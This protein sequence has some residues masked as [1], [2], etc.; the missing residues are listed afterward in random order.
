MEYFA[1]FCFNLFD[2]MI[3]TCVLSES[4]P[5]TLYIL[6]NWWGNFN[7]SHYS[8]NHYIEENSLSYF[9]TNNQLQQSFLSKSQFT[10]L[11]P[12]SHSKVPLVIRAMH[13]KVANELLLVQYLQLSAVLQFIIDFSMK[14][15]RPLSLFSSSVRAYFFKDLHSFLAP[16]SNSDPVLSETRYKFINNAITSIVQTLPFFG[17]GMTLYISFC[18]YI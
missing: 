5:L 18:F 8:N 17:D 2:F 10:N 12:L 1:N 13:Q 4:E 11:D 14:G 15:A 16:G 7:T 6:D 3:Q 9:S